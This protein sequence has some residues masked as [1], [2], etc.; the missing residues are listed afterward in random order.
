MYSAPMSFFTPIRRRP[1]HET[2]DGV[3]KE[4]A[5]W[6]EEKVTFD[7]GYRG[8]RMSAYLFLP[9]NV[10]PPYQTVLFFPSARV[11]LFQTTKVAG[12]WAIS[13]F[14]TTSFRAAALSCIRSM[15]TP[16]SAG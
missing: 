1:L 12:T 3:V 4:T 13:N 14:S 11:I 10:R 7:T 15:R 2:V 9:K 5:D 8:E 6:R 16:M